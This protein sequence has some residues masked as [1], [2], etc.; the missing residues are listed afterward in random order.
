M[1]E[2]GRDYLEEEDVV[3]DHT[4]SVKALGLQY[5]FQVSHIYT[6]DAFL[7]DERIIGVFLDENKAN[8]VVGNLKKMP[9]FIEHQDEFIISRFTLNNRLWTTGF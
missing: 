6:I 4:K 3:N 1:G 8:K 5:I 2:I 9:W 7:D